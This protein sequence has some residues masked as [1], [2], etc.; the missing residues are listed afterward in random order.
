MYAAGKNNAGQLGLGGGKRLGSSTEDQHEFV[1]ISCTRGKRFCHVS[2]GG[3]ITIATTDRHEVYV[4]GGLGLGP[5]GLHDNQRSMYG[6]PQLIEKLNGEEIIAASMGASHACASSVGGDLFVWGRTGCPKNYE[7][8]TPQPKYLAATIGGGRGVA[9]VNCGEMHTCVRTHENEAF[10]WGHGANGR[11]GR[12]GSD[13]APCLVRL[14]SP[15]AAV[16][17]IACGSEHTLLCTQLTVYSFGCGDGGRLGHGDCSDRH[18]P[19]EIDALKGSYPLS[20]SAGIW[21]SACV[22]HVAPLHESGWLWTWGSG[23]QGQLGQNQTCRA[24]TPTLV[25]DFVN[26]GLSVKEVFCGR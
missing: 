6:T 13:H 1:V 26:E 22:L 21:H 5:S 3:N 12:E 24:S 19:C 7:K 15:S 9:A 20:I 10:T 18:E 16:R 14:P 8:N 23:F 11:L 2:T 17:L 4:W 25:Q